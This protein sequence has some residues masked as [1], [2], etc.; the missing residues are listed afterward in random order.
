MRRKDREI[1]EKSELLAILRK[2]DSC[3]VAFAVDNTPYIVCMNHAVKWDGELPVIYFHCAHEGRKI[4]MMKKNNYVCFQA[5]TD[6]KLEYMAEKVYCTM[7]YSSITGMG[8]LKIV[9]DSHERIEALNHIMEHH[10]HTVP[11]KYPEGS[12]SRTT[13][14]RLDVTEIYGKKKI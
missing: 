12:L 9:E 1:V 6:H 8:Y 2:A 5:D 3:R 14:I 4:D 11:D 13:V 7:N 10:G